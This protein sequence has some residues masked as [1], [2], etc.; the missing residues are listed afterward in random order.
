MAFLL[1]ILIHLYRWLVS[2]L[3]HTLCGGNGCGC[4]F[5]PTCSLYAIQALTLHGFLR[6]SWLSLQRIMRCHPWS[7]YGGLDPVP[8]QIPICSHHSSTHS[9]H[10]PTL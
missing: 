5:H 7:R 4:R 10:S 2:P 9:H 8:P 6:G 1:R 3:L